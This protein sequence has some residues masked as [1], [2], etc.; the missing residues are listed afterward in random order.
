LW[1]IRQALLRR[2]VAPEF[3]ATSMLALPYAHY[4]FQRAELFHLSLGIFPLLIGIFLFSAELSHRMQWILALVVA[5]A[6]LIV[7][8]PQHPGWNCLV[9]EPC[10]TVEI[11]G[12]TLKIE[13]LIATFVTNLESTVAEYA[14][15][16]RNYLV[17]PLWPAAYALFKRKSPMWDSHAVFP[18]SAE[19]ERKEI[20]RIK[21]ANPSFALVLDQAVDGRDDLR[22]RNSHPLTYQFVRDHFDHVQSTIWHPSIFELYKAR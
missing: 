7:V 11:G 12:N 15:D 6:S 16:G 2:P 5:C 13:P 10:V 20:E 19:F 22:F 4:T 14:P 8:L 21:A 17:T 3:V 1:V 9:I 18:R